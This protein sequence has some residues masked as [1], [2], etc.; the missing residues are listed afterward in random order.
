MLD[1]TK[2]KWL[3]EPFPQGQECRVGNGVQN[4]EGADNPNLYARG[5]ASEKVHDQLLLAEFRC[6]DTL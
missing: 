5:G 3:I 1:I 6:M 2:M 4:P